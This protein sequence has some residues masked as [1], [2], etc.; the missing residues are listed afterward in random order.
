MDSGTHLSRLSC[1][2]A[3]PDLSLIT[4]GGKNL[5]RRVISGGGR[6]QRVLRAQVYLWL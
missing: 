2:E 4:N 1:R 5:L 3:C 6:G